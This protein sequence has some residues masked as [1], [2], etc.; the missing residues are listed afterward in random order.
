MIIGASIDEDSVYIT[1]P[2]H[3]HTINIDQAHSGPVSGGRETTG[4]NGFQA[5]VGV[6]GPGLGGGAHGGLGGRMGG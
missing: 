3:R 6:G 1:S 5:V 2:E 4:D